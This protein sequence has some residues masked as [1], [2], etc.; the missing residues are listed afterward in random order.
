MGS[1]FDTEPELLPFASREEVKLAESSFADQGQLLHSAIVKRLEV[2]RAQLPKPTKEQMLQ[3]SHAEN[4]MRVLAGTDDAQFWEAMEAEWRRKQKPDF[5]PLY[6]QDDWTNKAK[7]WLEEERRAARIYKD[8]DEANAAFVRSS[9]PPFPNPS[10]EWRRRDRINR[11]IQSG[12]RPDPQDIAEEE[13]EELRYQLQVKQARERK[14]RELEPA[15]SKGEEVKAKPA[16]PDPHPLNESPKS[17]KE[18]NQVAS[19][20]SEKQH[21]PYTQTKRVSKEEMAKLLRG[22]SPQK[23]TTKTWFSRKAL[24]TFIGTVVIVLGLVAAALGEAGV[25]K[26]GWTHLFLFCAWVVSVAGVCVGEGFEDKGAREIIRLG[27]VTAVLSGLIILGIDLLIVKEKAE[28]DAK[29]LVDAQ[30]VSPAVRS[31]PSL[32]SQTKNQTLESNRNQVL[33]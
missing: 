23:P 12:G 15:F 8:A 26:M 33:R 24:R 2:W 32:P 5:P 20:G 16:K 1:F 25:V 13:A 31:Q 3:V 22:E 18:T 29:S 7:D 9:H 4:R 14:L 10:K 17:T 30:T 28:A 11:A 27:C 19:S 21:K 6:P